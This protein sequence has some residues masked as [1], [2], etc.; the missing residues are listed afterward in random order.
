MEIG[1]FPVLLSF[2]VI[3]GSLG[4]VPLRPS[5]VFGFLVFILVSLTKNK[6]Y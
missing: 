4:I 2:E 5:A 6:N 1:K 3:L